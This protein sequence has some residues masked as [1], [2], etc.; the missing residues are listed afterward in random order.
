MP[1]GAWNES[2]AS[3]LKPGTEP[4]DMDVISKTA[5]FGGAVLLSRSVILVAFLHGFDGSSCIRKD[6]LLWEGI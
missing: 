1:P 3:R 5:P 6:A 2:T 4:I